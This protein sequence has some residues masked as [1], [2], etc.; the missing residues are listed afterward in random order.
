[1]G[2]GANVF[3]NLLLL[4]HC[5]AYDIYPV[6]FDRFSPY[7]VQAKQY[8]L[9]LRPLDYYYLT[10]PF[11]GGTIAN[12][13]YYFSDANLGAP[14]FVMMARWIEKLKEQI[15]TWKE[16]WSSGNRPSLHFKWDAGSPIIYDSRFDTPIE[17][18]LGEI[19]YVLSEPIDA[20]LSEYGS[21]EN[22]DLRSNKIRK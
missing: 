1:M 16:R 12:I 9:E 21:C 19:N 14:Y 22:Q 11:G 4:K 18:R 13:A 17:H 7:F 3:I 6:R 10:Y 2:K 20:N 15:K 8:E 5:V